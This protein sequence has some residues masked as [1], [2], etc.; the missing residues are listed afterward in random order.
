MQQVI[1]WPIHPYMVS[2]IFNGRSKSW[3]VD[4]NFIERFN[5]WIIDSRYRLIR[6]IMEVIRTKPMNRLGIM[7]QACDKWINEFS[8]S[9][10]E[11][12]QINKGLE[13]GCVVLFN[14]YTGYEISEG[15]DTHIICLTSKSCTYRGWDLSGILY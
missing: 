15:E 13:V 14:G 11:V 7:G 9:C 1:S 5:A 10:N 12:F 6:F 4:N 3:V 8:P 2:C